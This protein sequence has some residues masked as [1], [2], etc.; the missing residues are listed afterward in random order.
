MA[1]DEKELTRKDLEE[2]TGGVTGTPGL[3]N[4]PSN[5][6]SDFGGL[7]TDG[8]GTVTPGD[9]EKPER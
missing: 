7:S 6:V 2:V 3:K 9:D 8:D 4:G 1:H 5:D